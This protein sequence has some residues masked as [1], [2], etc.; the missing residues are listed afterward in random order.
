VFKGVGCDESKE[1]GIC[2]QGRGCA[3]RSDISIQRN[4]Y[5]CSKCDVCSKKWVYV[6]KV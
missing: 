3:Q 6:L 5:M 2:A 4:G 1:M